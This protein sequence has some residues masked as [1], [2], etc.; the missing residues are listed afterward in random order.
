M[1][2][3]VGDVA[4]LARESQADARASALVAIRAIERALVEALNGEYL[5]G[6]PNIAPKGDKAPCHGFNLRTKS[7]AEAI[8]RS[9]SSLILARDGRF[10]VALAAKL[11]GTFAVFMRLVGDVELAA[12]D[13]ETIAPRVEEAIRIHVQ[14]SERASARYRRVEQLGVKISEALSALPKSA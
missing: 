2:T 14:R 3:R 7:G 1:N 5:R 6:L 13:L 12:E 8:S 11:P 9:G 4:R 10:Y